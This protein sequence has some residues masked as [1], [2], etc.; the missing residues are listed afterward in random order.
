MRTWLGTR[1]STLQVPTRLHHPGYTL[2]RTGGT[3]YGA[4]V[5]AM[6]QIM[7]WGSDPSTN[8]LGDHISGLFEV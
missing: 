5:R 7:P 6:D 3:M 8:S 1:Y 4:P 2:P